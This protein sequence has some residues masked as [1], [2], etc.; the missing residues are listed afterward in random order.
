MVYRSIILL[1]RQDPYRSTL[2]Y[3]IFGKIISRFWILAFGD[4][5]LHCGESRMHSA[6]KTHN[7]VYYWNLLELGALPDETMEYLPKIYAAAIFR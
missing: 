5:G 4:I 3:F 1:M 7:T 2:C 6:I